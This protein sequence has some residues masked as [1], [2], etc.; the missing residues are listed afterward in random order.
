MGEP[1]HIMSQVSFAVMK[2][3]A[4]NI[5]EEFPRNDWRK[6]GITKRSGRANV[7]LNSKING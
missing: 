4:P 2:I 7:T 5:W 1:I 6:Y 3:Q